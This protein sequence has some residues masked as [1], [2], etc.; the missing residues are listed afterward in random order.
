VE[1][2]GKNKEKD[3]RKEIIPYVSDNDGNKYEMESKGH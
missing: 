3:G 2:K 1:S